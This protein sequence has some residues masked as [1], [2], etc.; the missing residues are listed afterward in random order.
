LEERKIGRTK[1][2]KDG[3][4]EGKIERLRDGETK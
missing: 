1:I 3:R 4:L 2:R